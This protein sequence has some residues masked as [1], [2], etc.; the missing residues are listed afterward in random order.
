MEGLFE[1]NTIILGDFNPKKTTWG[2]T[3]TNARGSELG[4][5]INKAFLTLNDGT[6]TFPSNSYSSTDVLDLTFV[7]PGIFPYSSWRVLDNIGSDHLPILVKINLKVNH[8]GVKNLHWNFKKANWS[9][10]ENISNDL[11]RKNLF[12][13]TWKMNG[14]ISNTPFLQ[15]LSLQSLGGKVNR[16]I[17][18]LPTIQTLL[19]H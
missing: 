14:L 13:T 11:L 17:L 5:L 19:S 10:F 6:H 3:I 18:S 9:L 15:L 16:P 1:D 2:S 7:S 8:T 4:N 12:W